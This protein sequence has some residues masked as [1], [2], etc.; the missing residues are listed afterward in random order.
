MFNA[1]LTIHFAD[2]PANRF[3]FMPG[4]HFNRWDMVDSSGSGM[5]SISTSEMFRTLES[6]GLKDK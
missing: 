3:V 2:G 6:V 1:V 4:H 5:Y